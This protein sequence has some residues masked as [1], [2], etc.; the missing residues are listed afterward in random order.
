MYKNPSHISSANLPSN[1]LINYTKPEEKLYVDAQN[2]RFQCRD[3]SS[4]G[5]DLTKIYS[6]LAIRFLVVNK[7]SPSLVL[8]S[9]KLIV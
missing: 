1:I 8:N 2:L 3:Y 5:G 7:S 6:S 9:W 4:H